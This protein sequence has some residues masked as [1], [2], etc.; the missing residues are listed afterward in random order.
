M[1]RRSGL[2]VAMLGMVL[3][4]G[5]CDYRSKGFPKRIVFGKSGGTITETGAYRCFY[6][7]SEPAEGNLDSIGASMECRWLRIQRIG[8]FEYHFIAQPNNTGKRRKLHIER[9][10]DPGWTEIKIVQN[11]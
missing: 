2:L 5:S 4:M 3:L 10:E 11:D 8:K 9:F 6:F 7:T 1:K